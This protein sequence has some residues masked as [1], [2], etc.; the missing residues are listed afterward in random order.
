MIAM[1]PPP[2]VARGWEGR[3]NSKLRGKWP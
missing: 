2:A 3:V 1:A